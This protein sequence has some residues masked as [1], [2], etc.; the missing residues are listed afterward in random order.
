MRA[1]SCFLFSHEQTEMD[2]FHFIISLG[3][4]LFISNM[5]FQ[6]ISDS[7]A[8]FILFFIRQCFRV[9]DKK[10]YRIYSSADIWVILPTILLL[11]LYLGFYKNNTEAYE[12]LPKRIAY[13][14]MIFI[15]CSFGYLATPLKAA[16]IKDPNRPSPWIRWTASS[17]RHSMSKQTDLFLTLFIL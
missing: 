15:I 17:D 2:N 9:A 4:I 12:P 11:F 5:V 8:L 14:A 7:D 13:G 3:Y 1:C 6:D 16:I 10:H